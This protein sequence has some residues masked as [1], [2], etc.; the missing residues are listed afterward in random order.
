MRAP[1]TEL[2]WAAGF[3]DGEGNVRCWVSKKGAV[4]DPSRVYVYMQVQVYQKTITPLDRF[5][6]ALG[7]VGKIYGPYLTTAGNEYYKFFANGLEGEAAMR[8]IEP[9]LSGP[10]SE[11]LKQ[12]R[13][14]LASYHGRLP[15]P[16]GPVLR[17][18]A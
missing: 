4:R 1:E 6:T 15:L 3:F 16:K 7:R 5:Q 18:A 12:A 9:Y 10:K 17:A 11:Q 14:V 2:A 13:E 8:L